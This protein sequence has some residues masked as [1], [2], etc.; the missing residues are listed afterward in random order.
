MTRRKTPNP[1]NQKH[2]PPDAVEQYLFGKLNESTRNRLDRQRQDDPLL[3]D[4]LDGLAGQSKQ[5]MSANMADLR[6]RLQDRIAQQKPVRRVLRPFGLQPYAMAASVALVLL[7]AAVVLFNTKFFQKQQMASRK[8]GQPA[9][10]AAT[11]ETQ[12]RNKADKIQSE[13][14]LEEPVAAAA[15]TPEMASETQPPLNANA[16]TQARASQKA[17]AG[18]S[19]QFSAPAAPQPMATARPEAEAIAKTEELVVLEEKMA[20]IP[21]ESPR[22]E[23]VWDKETA[24]RKRSSAIPAEADDAKSKAPKAVLRADTRQ[25]TAS[26]AASKPVTGTSATQMVRGKV[27]D[28]ED[29]LGI[30]GVVVTVKGTDIGAYTDQ[31]GNYSL[32]VPAGY[33]ELSFTFIGYITYSTPVDRKPVLDARLTPDVKA[34]SEVVVAGANQPNGQPVYKPAQP[35]NGMEDFV[36][37]LEQ[38]LESSPY[39]GQISG[40]GI[41]KLA[42]T[43]QP[44]GSLT[45]VKVLKGICDNCDAVAAEA[46]QTSPR[47]KPAEENGKPVAQKVKI[48]VPVKGKKA[49]K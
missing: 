22:S 12:S 14:K 20:A 25:E 42:F 2:L 30:P 45:N 11:P 4:A 38:K 28:S 36:K 43:V 29:G 10:A 46:V 24:A 31:D 33:N 15:Q 1:S 26:V 18:S 32:T 48:R 39:A 23:A 27:V 35:F 8:A 34:L 41:I 37:T 13:I 16:R 21:T 44:D 6:S 7:C 47:W 17:K 9:I 5:Q 40:S 3:S 49:K 19:P